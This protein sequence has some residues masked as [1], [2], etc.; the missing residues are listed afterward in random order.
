MK[1]L[2]SFD[3]NVQS[4]ME[5][6]QEVRSSY[7]RFFT[8]LGIHFLAAEASSGDMGGDTSH[9]YHAVSGSG[10]DRVVS[11]P[12]CGYSANEEVAESAPAPARMSPDTGRNIQ[13]W[14]GISK[15]RRTLVNAWYSPDASSSQA[16]EVSS[17]AIKRILPELD[18][19]IEDATPYWREALGACRLGKA[20]AT[21][22][23]LVDYRVG[24]LVDALERPDAGTLS[25]MFPGGNT[26]ELP[27]HLRAVTSSSS[28]PVD[29]LKIQPG[30]PCPKC[31]GGRLHVQTTLELGHT[32][33]LG[34]R[35]SE[36]LGA[37]VAGP[38]S[39]VHIQMGCYGIG[40]TRVMGALADSCSDEKGLLWPLEV[41][42]Y[43]L[44][45]LAEQQLV[46]EAVALYDVVSTLV[47]GGVH[48]DAVVDERP[49][50]LVWKM[51]DA[52]LIGYP[53]V[54]ILGRAW[55]K[56]LGCEV[57]CRKLGI[58]THVL[59]ADLPSYISSLVGRLL[60]V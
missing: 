6:Y 55:T 30:H 52:D 33:H 14:R 11:C 31:R 49:K 27:P 2:Y 13:V 56:G 59:P 41:A 8:R 9:E 7:D 48:L 4:A 12:S 42:P 10:E 21:L 45:I 24:H 25:L 51:K 17:H 32:F 22:V 23:N 26:H 3:T 50:S 53:I 43:G 40:L 54:V 57:Q 60:S 20:E 28:A 37:V 34:T 15:D 5:T 18:S 35:Y 16:S 38:E 58:Q 39:R 29:L 36:P 47:C 19:S 44:A 1:D 46:G